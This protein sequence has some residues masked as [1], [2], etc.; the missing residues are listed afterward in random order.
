MKAPCLDLSRL[1]ARMTNVL[2]RILLRLYY[3][4]AVIYRSP[5][6]REEVQISRLQFV[7]IGLPGVGKTMFCLKACNSSDAAILA[8][9]ATDQKSQSMLPF[10]HQYGRRFSLSP[11]TIINY[12]EIG[13]KEPMSESKRNSTYAQSHG[14]ILLIDLTFYPCQ[15]K[16]IEFLHSALDNQFLMKKPILVV[17]S[18]L[19]RCL[20]RMD[21]VKFIEVSSI[22]TNAG[23]L[24]Y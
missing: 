6:C 24:H 17:G 22:Y 10:S 18:K 8:F 23:V 5:F 21:T 7:V 4:P 11:T 14:V 12:I 9:M 1:G 16:S 3:S 19:D 15:A 20:Q 2:R 13:G